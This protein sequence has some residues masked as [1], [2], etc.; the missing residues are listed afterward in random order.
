M[1]GA[2]KIQRVSGY[3]RIFLLTRLMRGATNVTINDNSADNNFYSRASCEARLTPEELAL[4]TNVNFYSRASCEARLRRGILCQRPGTFLLTR[5]M[6]GATRA[7]KIKKVTSIIST[8][9][10]HARRDYLKP[11]LSGKILFLLTRLM[12]GATRFSKK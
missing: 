4:M 3:V 11:E 1:R 9:A 7:K 2:T 5:L 10:P 6:R 12:R 8:H